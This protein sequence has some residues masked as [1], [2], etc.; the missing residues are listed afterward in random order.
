MSLKANYE[1]TC[2]TWTMLNAWMKL[3]CVWDLK[4]VYHVRST[5]FDQEILLIL[6]VDITAIIYISFNLTDDLF[7]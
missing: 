5:S 2:A 6:L 7:L 4:S 3:E 1:Y